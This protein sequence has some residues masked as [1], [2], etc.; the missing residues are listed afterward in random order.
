MFGALFFF[1][2][3][4]GAV[5]FGS[6]YVLLAFLRPISYEQLGLVSEGQLLDAIAVGQITLD[7][8]L[9][10]PHS[11][12]TCSAADSRPARNGGDLSTAFVFVALSGR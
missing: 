3:K 5:L 8:S 4:I 12:V 11:S 9:Q 1:F 7:H 10:P 6:G 2:L